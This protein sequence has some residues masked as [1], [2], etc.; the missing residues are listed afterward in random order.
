MGRDKALLPYRGTVL[1]GWVASIVEQA[2]GSVSLVGGGEKYVHLGY[3]VLEESYGG[4]GPLSG[5]E[6]ALGR[7]AEWSLIV[8]CDMAG[9]ESG[10]LRELLAVADRGGAQAVYACRGDGRAE[11]LCAVYHRDCLPSVRQMLAS[12]ELKVQSLLCRIKA[13]AWTAG[14]VEE[15]RNI[16]TPG[17]WAS[18][19][20][21]G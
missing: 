2:A 16:N 21:N 15:L 10:R 18:A 12:G 9:I 1:A 6:A 17:D 8:A 14:W 19:K 20:D 11:P 7:G 3:P 13:L 5:I 4:L